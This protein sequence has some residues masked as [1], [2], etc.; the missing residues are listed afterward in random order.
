TSRVV[1]LEGVGHVPMIEVP[2]RTAEEMRQT[3]AR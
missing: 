1:I 3:M 2:K